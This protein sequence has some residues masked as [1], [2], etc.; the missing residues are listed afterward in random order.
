VEIEI[1]SKSIAPGR[2]HV[3]LRQATIDRLYQPIP[4]SRRLLISQLMANS[5]TD[6]EPA[7]LHGTASCGRTRRHVVEGRARFS[8]RYEFAAEALRCR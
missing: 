7:S 5:V 1:S 3:E 4:A 2:A 6:P 8:L